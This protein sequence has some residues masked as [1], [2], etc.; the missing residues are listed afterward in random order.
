M[1][2]H[3]AALLLAVVAVGAGAG[4]AAGQ[5]VR[6]DAIWAR[7][8]AGAPITLDGLLNEAV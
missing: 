6:K 2:T 8:T 4:P 7:S 3:V 5:A 1:K